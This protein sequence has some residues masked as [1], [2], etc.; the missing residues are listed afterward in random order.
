MRIAVYPGSFD[1]ITNGHLDVIERA[2]CLFD[3]LIVAVS[4]NTNKKPLFTV[5]EREEMLREVL[6]PYYNVIVDSFDGLTVNYARDRGAQA[7]VRG[8]RA[9]SDFENEF[10]MALTNKKLVPAVD[11]VFLMTRAE[12]SFISSSAV[13]EVAY[14]GGCVRDLV[15]PAVENRLRE[16]FATRL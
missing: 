6:Q 14:F 8:L 9:I 16:K 13:K 7:I 3:Q 5:Q 12:F 2:A 1:P 11:T 4:R 15:P 10:M